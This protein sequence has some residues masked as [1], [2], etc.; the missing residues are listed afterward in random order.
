MYAENFFKS[1]NMLQQVGDSDER[2]KGHF[3]V[4][5]AT[6]YAFSL[7]LYFKCRI[8]ASS[9]KTPQDHDLSNLFGKITLR[10]QSRIRG[11]YAV[12]GGANDFFVT[13]LHENHSLAHP[14]DF[15]GVL[16]DSKDAFEQ[17]RYVYE[18]SSG[19]KAGKGNPTFSA[20]RILMAT[21]FVINELHP[22]WIPNL[23]S[24]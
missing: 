15:D 8:T 10:T 11:V 19:A 4:P 24:I 23:K 12:Y 18:Y 9:G 7:E 20:G 16:R 5:V 1:A 2:I 17:M 3:L 14:S 22:D 21:R 13:W 6:L